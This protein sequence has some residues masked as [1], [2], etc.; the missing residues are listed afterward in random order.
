MQTKRFNYRRLL[1]AS[2]VTG[3]YAHGA[4]QALA[5]DIK[6]EVTGSNIKRIEGE[7]ALPVQVIGREEIAKSGATNAM[8]IMNLISANN[9]A[10]N[11]SVGNA[12]GALTLSNQTAS[13]RGLGGS[14][15]LV[16]VNGKR[17]GTFSGGISGAEGVNLAAIPFAA[18]ERV[19]V[20]KDGASAV[21]G[22]DAIGGV[23]N[24]IMRQ[25]FTGVDAT[26]WYGTPTRSGGG[27]QYQ[28]SAT[29][30]YG[31]LAKDKWNAFLAVNYSEQKSLD[32]FDRTFSN[33]NY[34]PGP[35]LNTTSGQTFP[36]FISTIGA[37]NGSLDNG[38]CVA[39]EIQIGNRCRYN[40]A[41]QHGVNS[42][43]DTKQLN[44][45]GSGR[46]QINPD[47]QAYVTGL[48]SH[49]ETTYQIQPTPLSDQVPTT[50]TPTGA[51]TI[52]LQPTSPFYP[53]QLAADNGVGGQPL[54]IRYRCVVCGNRNTTDT[55]EAWQVVAGAKGTAWNWD[56]DGSFNY[57]QN[58]NNEKVNNGFF[59]YTQIDALLNSGVVNM[60][61]PNTD[62]VQQQVDALSIRRSLINSK[63]SGYGVNFTGSGD[64]YKLPAGPLA[65]ALGLQAGKE[66][67]TQNFD[68]LLGV[69]DVTGYGGN[70]LDIDVSRTVWAVFGELNIPILKNLEGNIAVRYDH[71][72]DFGS[73]T[74]PK[75][76]LRYQPVQSL[77]LRA[78]YG[79]GFL[80]PSLYEMFTPVVPGLSQPGVSDPLRCPDPNAPGSENNPDCNTQYTAT[81]GGNPNLKPEKANQ[82]TVGFVWEPLN[83]ASIGADWFYLDLKDIVTNGVPIATILAPATYSLYSSL[84]TRAATCAGGQPC[85]ITAIAQ[86]FVNIGKEKIQGIDV[87][88]RFTGPS[89][90]IGRFR[91]ILTGTYYIQYLASQP[92][93]S[94]AGFVSNAYAAPATGITPRWK[95]YAALSW[96]YGPWTAT[97]AN[98]YQS[99]YI[100]VTTDGNGD[101]RRVGSLSTWDVQGSYT[102]FKDWTLTLGAKNVFDTNP[103]FTNSFLTFQSGYDPS[104]Y[105]ARARVVYGSVRWTWK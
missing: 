18:I 34:N 54:N 72:S 33:T 59:Q 45:F 65:L 68:P 2:A 98:N 89:T 103:P 67:L 38:N 42:I 83:G 97:L 23:I 1:L 82:T 99:S 32:Q 56:F 19:E 104:Y 16:L 4:G 77:L 6:V 50:A 39:P 12:I 100:D 53:T 17:L 47:W 86:N 13:L 7:G 73:T 29:V 88:A 80:A 94:F 69:G 48:Y 87:D 15:T 44:L 26:A 79:T 76:S 64:I 49:Q 5:A 31:D 102:G 60:F 36:G 11:V 81:F 22:S 92:D 95:S 25:D 41:A 84:V 46:Y 58:T 24:F 20:L 8:E 28:L 62:A 71:Y 9:S 70:N 105:D 61:G 91:A 27:D 10:G 85:P 96:D 37:P 43:P 90:D 55:N 101:F 57:S 78:S 3:L 66:T 52:T 74:N 75:F 93:G 21:Y 30:G 35:G 40:P 14:S 51:A 63:L